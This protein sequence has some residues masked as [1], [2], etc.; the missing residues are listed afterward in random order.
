MRGTRPAAAPH[1]N[2]ALNAAREDDVNHFTRA[3]HPV[4][5]AR[6]AAARPAAARPAA[7]RLTAIR[8]AAIRA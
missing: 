5:P 7:I 3:P 1:K 6:P 4:R 2:K 8:P